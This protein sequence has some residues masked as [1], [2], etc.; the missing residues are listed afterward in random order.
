MDPIFTDRRWDDSSYMGCGPRLVDSTI[1]PDNVNDIDKPTPGFS[2]IVF[3]QP[4]QPP[5][6]PHPDNFTHLFLFRPEVICQDTPWNHQVSDRPQLSEQMLRGD[7]GSSY[8]LWLHEVGLTVGFMVG[9]VWWCVFFL[10]NK[11]DLGGNHLVW[12]RAICVIPL[13]MTHV[14]KHMPISRSRQSR[15]YVLS[16]T[17][18]KESTGTGLSP[19]TPPT[20][21]I[22]ILFIWNVWA[23]RH[24]FYR[25][26]GILSKWSAAPQMES[27]LHRFHDKLT[28]QTSLLGL[29]A[30][31]R[32]L[33]GHHSVLC[34]CLLCA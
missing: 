12:N 28:L 15:Q 27:K 26:A 31:L 33:K 6:P 7:R 22:R 21:P 20:Y 23:K 25:H 17:Q 1:H 13:L 29:H 8:L 4:P 34:S 2:L 3:R 5:Q 10:T 18:W 32:R 19:T 30:T 11:H 9:I 24:I 16:S 14:K